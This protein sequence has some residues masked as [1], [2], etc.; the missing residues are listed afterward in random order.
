MDE[1]NPP[2]WKDFILSDPLFKDLHEIKSKVLSSPDAD[3]HYAKKRNFVSNPTQKS[4]ED[5]FQMTKQIGGQLAKATGILNTRTFGPPTVLDLCMAPGGFGT[6]VKARFPRARIDG[7]TLPMDMGGN[8]VMARNVFREIVYADIT[9]FMGETGAVKDDIPS[10]HPDLHNF[11]LSSP[12]QRT[13]YDLIFCGGGVIKENHEREAYREDCEGTRL[14]LSQ[15]VF[16]LN[17]LRSGGCL[18]ILLH[19]VQSWDTASLLYTL[20]RFARIQA[21]KSFRSHGVTSSFYLVAEGVDMKSKIAVQAVKY[22]KE[23]WKYLTFKEYDGM[24]EP[25]VPNLLDISPEKLI[26]EFG[27]RLLE[28]ARPLW[29]IQKGKLAQLLDS[30]V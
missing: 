17:R 30:L 1:S 22:W 15:L 19:R 18:V 5:M 11:N 12:Y 6:T 16:A 8:E 14:T 21:F 2:L 26:S 27:E 13:E 28:I 20:S 29:E 25:T 4:K 3:N 24:Q 9:M 10:Q 23:V 7:L